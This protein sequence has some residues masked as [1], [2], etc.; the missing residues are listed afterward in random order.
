MADRLYIKMLIL[1]AFMVMSVSGDANA[2]NSQDK[3]TAPLHTNAI[4]AQGKVE[5]STKI[6]V[7]NPTPYWL[8][9]WN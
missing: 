7:P 1:P 8:W 2:L 3:T 4:K 9:E 5:N 6:D